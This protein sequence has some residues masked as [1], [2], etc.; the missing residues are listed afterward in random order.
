MIIVRIHHIRAANLCAAGARQWFAKYDLSWS[1]FLTNGFSTDT[2]EAT[3]DA[4][5]TLVSDIARKEHSDGR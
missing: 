1:E 2:L 3:R 5:A 4:L